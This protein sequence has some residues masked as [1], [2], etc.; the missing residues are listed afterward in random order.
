MAQASDDVCNCVEKFLE[1]C[2]IRSDKYKREI[3]S[4]FQYNCC[5]TIKSISLLSKKDLQRMELKIGHVNLVYN[6]INDGTLDE[7]RY[8]ECIKKKKKVKTQCAACD[9]TGTVTE[10]Y[11]KRLY[12]RYNCYK[13]DG[14]GYREQDFNYRGGDQPTNQQRVDRFL[15][16]NRCPTCNDTRKVQSSSKCDN[17]GGDG[18]GH[19]KTERAYRQVMCVKCYGK[20]KI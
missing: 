13:C 1:A 9:G 11:E 20:G 18:L 14:T 15:W 12:D 19:W 17:C 10:E 3:M 4:K 2:E 5:E 8:C 7:F 6:G 16:K